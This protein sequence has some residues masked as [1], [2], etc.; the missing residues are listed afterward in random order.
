MTDRA[1]YVGLLIAA[2]LI[3]GILY[4]AFGQLTVK[5]LRK[6]PKTKDLLG[7]EYVSGWDIIN[8]AQALAFPSKWSEKLGKS[9][10]SFIYAN[11]KVLAENT[12]KFDRL[13]GSAFYWLL[14]ITGLSSALLALL[15]FVGYFH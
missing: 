7:L 12:T 2:A 10:L 15:N 4:L 5:K 6:N 1:L 9:S 14:I 13:L 11:E 3:V 8:V